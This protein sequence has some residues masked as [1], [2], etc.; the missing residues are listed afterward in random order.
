M[1]KSS[2]FSHGELSLSRKT[3]KS[4]QQK[5]LLGF[6]KVLDKK[7]LFIFGIT[8]FLLFVLFSFLVHKDLFTQLDFDTTV[9]IQDRI[10]RNFDT[11]FSVF[12]LLGSAEISTLVLLLIIILRRKIK[13]SLIFIGYLFS[14]FFEL[15][16][17]I[18]VVHPPPP[19]LF[20]RY[21]IPFNFPSTYVQP[22]SSYPSGHSTRTAFISVVLLFLIFRSKKLTLLHKKI[23]LSIIV[24]FDIIMFASRVYLGEHWTSDVIGGGLLG[25]SLGLISLIAF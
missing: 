12:S 1:N 14:F 5:I 17:K 11:P 21:D 7:P 9:K 3:N 6:N 24:L 2:T 20:F 4:N 23:L 25:A 16:G 19:F 8:I 18:F 15:F 10:G 13:G 22:G